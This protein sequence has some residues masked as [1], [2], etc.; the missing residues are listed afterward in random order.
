[1]GMRNATATVHKIGVPSKYKAKLK[2]QI[3]KEN[4]VNEMPSLQM[5]LVKNKSII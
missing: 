2:R 4:N 1:M 5:F 3:L